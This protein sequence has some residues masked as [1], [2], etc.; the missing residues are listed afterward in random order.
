MDDQRQHSHQRG[1][2]D[3]QQSATTWRGRWRVDCRLPRHRGLRVRVWVVEGSAAAG[4]N[5]SG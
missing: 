5:G 3:Q 2:R 1:Q 4:V